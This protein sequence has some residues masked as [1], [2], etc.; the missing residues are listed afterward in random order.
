MP[1]RA[2]AARVHRWMGL[3]VGVQVLLW[4]AGGVVMSVLPIEEVR[5]EHKLAEHAPV[6]FAPE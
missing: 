3:L 5:S 1:V 2:V 6:A 4:I